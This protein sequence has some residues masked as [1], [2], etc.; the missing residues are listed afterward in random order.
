MRFTLA[1]QDR[2]SSAAESD[3]VARGRGRSGAGFG[4]PSPGILPLRLVTSEGLTYSPDNVWSD[5]T[6]GA[7]FA[8][9]PLFRD[10]DAPF[11]AVSGLLGN[12]FE[13]ESAPRERNRSRFRLEGTKTSRFQDPHAPFPGGPNGLAQ[14][15]EEGVRVDRN[16][17]ADWPGPH[18]SAP[19][20]PLRQMLRTGVPRRRGRPGFPR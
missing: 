17:G 6:R 7:V 18:G 9:L 3:P 16:P 14:V 5:S 4:R 12:V 8:D 15:A 1:G 20:T 13:P 10:P 19:T 2:G 11:R